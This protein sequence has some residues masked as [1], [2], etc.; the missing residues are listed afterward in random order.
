MPTCCVQNCKSRTFHSNTK[1]ISY[2]CFPK[3]INIRQQWVDACVNRKNIKVESGKLIL[4][5]IYLF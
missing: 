5:G 2:Y 1:G 4:F 3:E